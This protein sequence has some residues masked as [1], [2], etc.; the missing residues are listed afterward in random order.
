MFWLDYHVLKNPDGVTSK[1][2]GK[3][4]V[5]KWIW[6]NPCVLEEF[7]VIV[8]FGKG[9][10]RYEKLKITWSNPYVSMR[11]IYMKSKNVLHIRNPLFYFVATVA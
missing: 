1:G 7:Y 4:F 9:L 5:L 8:C 10:T 3:I 11:L 6:K 2:F